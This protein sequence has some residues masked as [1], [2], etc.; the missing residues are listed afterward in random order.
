MAIWV[1]NPARYI[2]GYNANSVI[3]LNADVVL[4]PRHNAIKCTILLG[5]ISNINIMFEKK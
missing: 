5:N 2:R 4:F 3:S 1:L